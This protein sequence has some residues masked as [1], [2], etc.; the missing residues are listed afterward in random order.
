MSR[1]NVLIQTSAL[2]IFLLFVL[3]PVSPSMA[4]EAA[5][6][7]SVAEGTAIIQMMMQKRGGRSCAPRSYSVTRVFQA[8]SPRFKKK[9]VMTV[10]T[11]IGPDGKTESKL[12][13][14]EGS[15]FIRKQVFQ[16]ILEAEHDANRGRQEID[17]TPDNYRFTYEGTE[18]W[19]GRESYVFRIAPLRK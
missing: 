19:K 6:V 3:T 12:I 2:Q 4:G 15:D 11:S 18:I 9:A 13:A 17:I 5:G 7:A 16:K 8:E 14:D 1:S 10:E